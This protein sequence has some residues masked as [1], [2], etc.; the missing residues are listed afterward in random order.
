MIN[1]SVA[2]ILFCVVSPVPGMVLGTWF[3]LSECLWRK[4]YPMK[5]KM[6]PVAAVQPSGC[7]HSF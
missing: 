1:F 4:T 7:K 6:C 5:T 2:E 3:V